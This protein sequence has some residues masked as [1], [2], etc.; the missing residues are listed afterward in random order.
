MIL[1]LPLVLAGLALFP[2]ALVFIPSYAGFLLGT[3]FLTLGFLRCRWEATVQPI[4]LESELQVRQ[5][6]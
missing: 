2:F 3:G 5:A 6:A 1:Y 4:P